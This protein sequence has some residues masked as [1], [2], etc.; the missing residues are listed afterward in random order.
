MDGGARRR[1]DAGHHHGTAAPRQVAARRLPGAA[2]PGSTPMNKMTRHSDLIAPKVTTG[3]ISGSRK[4]Y[5]SQPGHPDLRVPLREIALTDP[6][7]ATFRV[8]DS[9]GPY[10]DPAA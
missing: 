7:Q 5:A 4:V 8:Y 6:E 3:P 2:R 1:L 10:T 9:S